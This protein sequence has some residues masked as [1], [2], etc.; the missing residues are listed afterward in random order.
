M[1]VRLG[2]RPSLGLV[3][4]LLRR[5]GLALIAEG[6]TTR[7]GKLFC[8]QTIHKMFRNRIYLG[9]IVHKG[10]SFPGQHE[11][12]TTQ[13]EWDASHGQEQPSATTHTTT[14]RPIT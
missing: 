9:E 12:I 5:V 2:L 6:I 14:S 11:G 1:P 10:K 3:E 13:T 8:K 7:R 4:S